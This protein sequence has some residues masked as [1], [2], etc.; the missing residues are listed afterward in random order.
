VPAIMIWSARLTCEVVLFES[1]T[2]MHSRS[3]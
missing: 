3:P 1:H 2:P